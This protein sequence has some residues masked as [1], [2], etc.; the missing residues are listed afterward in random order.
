MFINSIIVVSLVF[1]SKPFVFTLKC[2][3]GQLKCPND[4]CDWAAQLGSNICLYYL[5]VFI[6]FAL[7]H[8]A[9]IAYK[10]M[11]TNRHMVGY[12]LNNQRVCNPGTGCACLIS[13]N[14]AVIAF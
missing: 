5:N 13:V 12:E 2:H 7:W 4:S 3:P 11:N 6:Y 9:L 10:S 1:P 14:D 8:V